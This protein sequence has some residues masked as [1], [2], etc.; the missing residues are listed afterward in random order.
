ME[1]NIEVEEFE[2]YLIKH[3]IEHEVMVEQRRCGS[4]DTTRDTVGSN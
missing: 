2:Q 1:E 4:L 3:Q